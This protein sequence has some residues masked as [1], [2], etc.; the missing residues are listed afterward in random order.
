MVYWGGLSVDG[1][2]VAFTGLLSLL[3]GIVFGLAPVWQASKLELQ[4]ALKEG[5]RASGG[6][7]RHRLRDALVVTEIALA[8]VLLVGAGLMMRSVWRLLEVN[9]GFRT[10]NLLTM[11]ISLPEAKYEEAGKTE[12]FYRQ[13]DARLKVLPGV[14]GVGLASRVPLQGGFTT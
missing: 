6:T 4:A 11:R 5:G 3:T 8:L 2:M 10:E 7:T 1:G 13:L 12:N 14:K 9:P